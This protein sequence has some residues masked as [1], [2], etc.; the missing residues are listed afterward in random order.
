MFG[1]IDVGVLP[2]TEVPPHQILNEIYGRLHAWLV[3]TRSVSVGVVFPQYRLDPIGLGSVVRLVGERTV[4]EACAV[5]SWLGPIREYVR[6]KSLR[7]V[8]ADAEWRRLVRVQVKSNPDRLRRRYAQRHGC[9][10]EDAVAI[11]PASVAKMAALP[12]LS[13]CSGSTGQAYRLYL[14]LEEACEPSNGPFNT[15]GLSNTATIPWF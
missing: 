12:F 13:L 10:F 15:F 7:D 1:H 9:S 2:Q 5:D 6:I 11:I 8:P 3:S 14:R 4:L